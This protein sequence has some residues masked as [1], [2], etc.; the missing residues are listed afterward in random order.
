MK[1]LSDIGVEA[2]CTL[3]NLT[4]LH[5][6]EQVMSKDLSVYFPL[7]TVSTL[8]EVNFPY[9]QT[10]HK[11]EEQYRSAQNIN[12]KSQREFSKRQQLIDHAAQYPNIKLS[13]EPMELGNL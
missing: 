13:W 10:Y 7:F 12:S 2:L 1:S 8:R 11:Y 5:I 3:P 9:Y 6:D 4:S